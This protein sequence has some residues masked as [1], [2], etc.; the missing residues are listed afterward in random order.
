MGEI[1]RVAGVSALVLFAFSSC[2]T[3]PASTEIVGEAATSHTGAGGVACHGAYLSDIDTAVPQGATPEAAAAAWAQSAVAPSGAPTAGWKAVDDL[4]LG[5][6]GWIV[7]V[8]HVSSV[9]WRV[10]GL[11]C[12]AAPCH[13][14]F[15]ADVDTSVPGEPTPEAAAVAWARSG[16]APA[17]APPDGWKATDDR[18]VRSG[19]WIVG[20][21]RTIP[22]GWV[23]SGL[24]CGV[25]QS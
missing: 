4:T 6:G 1:V 19:D 2:A 24:G 20:V 18:T 15:V 7:R 10:D 11:G 17:G 13:G 14:A 21:S 8:V 9:G 5:S 25:T 23:F 22:G 3:A 16:F 12:G